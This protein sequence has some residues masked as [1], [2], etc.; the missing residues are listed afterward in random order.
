MING[1]GTLDYFEY[2]FYNKRIL[3]RLDFITAFKA[4]KYYDAFNDID[5]RHKLDNK[6]ESYK[7]FNE[8]LGRKW[9]DV[10]DSTYKEFECF[11]E[12]IDIVIVKPK[13]GSFGE[14][15]YKQLV[16]DI[17]NLKE[18]YSDLKK[19]ESILE[20]L[21]IQHPIL[22][23]L[24][25][26]SLNTI[27]ITTVLEDDKVHVMNASLKIGNNGNAID[28]HAAGGIVANICIGSG[29]V[30]S[31]GIDRY[32]NRYELHPLTNIMIVGLDIPY[33][34]KAISLV[35]KLALRIPE[36]RHVGW[37]IAITPYGAI[38]IEGN[39]MAMFDVHQ[40]PTQVGL[41]PRYKR[42]LN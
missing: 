18:W 5:H 31:L 11:C 13:N 23:S 26:E 25:K 4:R 41:N 35:K 39:S 10:G 40:Q 14:G 33:W 3:A 28:N 38:L 9:L 37:D 16:S 42:F 15:I 21:V 27:R 34:D 7:I 8:Y 19:D 6:T 1:A 30:T 24:H 20:E 29:R 32:Q 2:E 12:N 36:I 22:S 17:E